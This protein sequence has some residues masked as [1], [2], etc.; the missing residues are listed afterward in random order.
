VNGTTLTISSTVNAGQAAIPTFTQ[1]TLA[2]APAAMT[3]AVTVSTALTGTPTV[4]NAPYGGVVGSL[5]LGG[6][7]TDTLS[8]TLNIGANTISLGT[9]T[10]P[11]RPTPW[12][13]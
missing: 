5:T 4:K 2:N 7:S 12:P 1:G 11:T 13:T 9:A 3:P 8:G 10:G 6:S